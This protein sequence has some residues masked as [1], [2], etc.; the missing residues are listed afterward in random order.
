MIITITLKFY[1]K[2]RLQTF[3]IK[4]NSL[5]F[6]GNNL[7]H[8]LTILSK[9]FIFTLTN[10]QLPL[11]KNTSLKLGTNVPKYAP[12]KFQFYLFFFNLRILT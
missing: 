6:N 2:H 5:T 4:I 1:C 12:Q 11:L 3:E 9:N 8:L 7:N 10:F